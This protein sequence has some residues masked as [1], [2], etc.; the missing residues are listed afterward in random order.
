MDI[1]QF[2]NNINDILDNGNIENIPIP[3]VDLIKSIVLDSNLN[4]ILFKKFKNNYKSIYGDD[5]ENFYMKVQ[6]LLYRLHL[7]INHILINNLDVNKEE[8][9]YDAIYSYV[10]NDSI[11]LYDAVNYD[12]TDLEE[13]KQDL[14]D[15][16]E[17]LS[18]R[19]KD[20]R[21]I[22]IPMLKVEIWLIEFMIC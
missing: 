7:L 22:G 8:V 12:D 13:L 1:K 5:L 15:E 21:G 14:L 19:W 18:I 20:K 16:S 3:N 6:D 2:N 4:K 10:I 17:E 11:S 9:I